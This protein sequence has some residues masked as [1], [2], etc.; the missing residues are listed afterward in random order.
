MTSVLPT[1]KVNDSSRAGYK[2]PVETDWKAELEKAERQREIDKW[3]ER[4]RHHKDEESDYKKS[5]LILLLML[6]ASIGAWYYGKEVIDLIWGGQ[7]LSDII[8]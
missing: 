5:A 7:T 4:Y 3:K 2:K 1:V 6:G 8:K